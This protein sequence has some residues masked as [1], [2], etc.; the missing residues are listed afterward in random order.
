W[1]ARA[2]VPGIFQKGEICEQKRTTV[3]RGKEKAQGQD[4]ID[5]EDHPSGSASGDTFRNDLA[6]LRRHGKTGTDG[7]LGKFPGKQ[8]GVSG[9]RGNSGAGNRG[10]IFGD[11][12]LR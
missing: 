1:S 11:G 10:R 9:T 2:S 12:K 6:G 8:P 4:K 7:I 3:S 5:L